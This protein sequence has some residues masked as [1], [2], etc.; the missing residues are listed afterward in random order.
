MADLG[1]ILRWAAEQI[2]KLPKQQ[3]KGRASA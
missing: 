1:L 2:E 3:T